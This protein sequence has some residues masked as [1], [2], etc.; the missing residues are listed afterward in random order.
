M[1]LPY[2]SRVAAVNLLP[3]PSPSP[4]P[5]SSGLPTAGLGGARALWGCQGP[6][7]A[8]PEGH[9]AMG[10][11]RCPQPLAHGQGHSTLLYPKCPLSLRHSPNSSPGVLMSPPD[12]PMTNSWPQLGTRGLYC[13]VLLH[14]QD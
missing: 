8:R 10:A 3:A 4:P 13:C 9:G 7:G 6:V 14:A 12:P 5:C 2:I 1:G 11:I